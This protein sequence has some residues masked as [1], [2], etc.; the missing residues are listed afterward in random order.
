[1]ARPLSE[2]KRQHLIQAGIDCMFEHGLSASTAMIAKTAGVATGSLF[3]YF[4]NKDALLNAVYVQIKHT[5]AEHILTG[6]PTENIFSQRLWH[7]WHSYINW[8]LTYPKHRQV[9][10]QLAVSGLISEDSQAQ[11]MAVYRPMWQMFE[12]AEQERRLFAPLLFSVMMM[13]QMAEITLSQIEQSP[14]QHEYYMQL[15][16]DMMWRAM[17][18]TDSSF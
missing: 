1:M 16:F 5:L 18:R 10:K 6:F 17:V 7:L 2:I 9:M 11:I 3:T 14:A 15:S 4:S 13:E 8:G 12:Q